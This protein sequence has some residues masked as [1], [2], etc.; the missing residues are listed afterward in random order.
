MFWSSDAMFEPLLVPSEEFLRLCN[1]QFDL[2]FNLPLMAQEFWRLACR[3][4][5]L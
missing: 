3:H 2:G 1:L 4:T 5:N